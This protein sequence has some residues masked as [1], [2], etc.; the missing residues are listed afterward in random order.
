MRKSSY[1]AVIASL[2][3]IKGQFV[4]ERYMLADDR[5]DEVTLELRALARFKTGEYSD[6]AQ[7][8]KLI[9]EHEPPCRRTS[10]SGNTRCS[11][12]SST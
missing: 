9:R 4:A 2:A 10:C 11:P 8:E 6:P 12:L 5:Y 3:R 7:V 1:R